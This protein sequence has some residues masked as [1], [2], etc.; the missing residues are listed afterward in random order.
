MVQFPKGSFVISSFLLSIVIV[1][2]IAVTLLISNVLSKTLLKGQ[3]SHYILEL[4]SYRRPEFSKVIVSSLLNRT[5]SVLLR[6]V[7]VSFP[8]GIVIWLLL[9]LGEKQFLNCIVAFFSGLGEFMGVD[10]EILSSFVLGIPANEIVL[11]VCLMLYTGGSELLS[12]ENTEVIAEILYSN[13]WSIKTAVCFI[14]FSLFHFPCATTLLTI[15]KET[16][17]L[18]WLVV[19]FLLPTVLGVFFCSVISFIFDFFKV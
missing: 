15:Y 8:A 10:G 17:S 6:A 3:K 2:S 13:G 7:T 11:P 14:L 4:P 19:S 18:K 5:F 16:K 9:N 1:F 12:V